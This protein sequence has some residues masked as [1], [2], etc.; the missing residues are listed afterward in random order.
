M[1]LKKGFFFTILAIVFIDVFLLSYQSDIS[2]EEFNSFSSISSRINMMEDFIESLEQDAER[3]LYISGYRAFITMNNYV[4]SEADPITSLNSTYK[5]V[6]INGT[7]YGNNTHTLLMDNQTLEDW[8]SRVGNLADEL[9]LKVNMTFYNV[10]VYQ[11]SPWNIK[12]SMMINYTLND[13]KKAASWNRNGRITAVI[14]IDDWIDPY[15][16]MHTGGVMRQIIKTNITD[17]NHSSVTWMMGNKTYMNST[18][19]PSFLDR[20]QNKTS[21]DKNGIFTII[22]LDSQEIKSNNTDDISMIDHYWF[23]EATSVPT[24]DIVNVTNRFSWFRLDQDYMHITNT[25]NETIFS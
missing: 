18:L 2:Y 5:E 24:A 3:A 13:T 4:I 19:A 12:T 1:R 7:L 8:V 15:Y 22:N 23:R 14:K 20:I 21:P 25:Q 9:D 17:L 16:A 11:T 10:T 6:I